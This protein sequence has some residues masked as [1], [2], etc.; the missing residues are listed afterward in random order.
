MSA[1]ISDCGKYRYLLTRPAGDAAF[2]RAARDTVVFCM[3]NPSTADA[4]IDDPTIRRC[5]GF[6]DRW[7]CAGIAVVNLYAYRATDPREL[8]KLDRITAVGPENDH[9]LRDVAAKSVGIVCAWGANAEPWRV[10]EVLRIFA[11]AGARTYCLGTTKAGHPR[12]PLYV[13]GCQPLVP[14]EQ[15]RAVG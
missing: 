15:G 11:A 12:H 3:L 5:R 10:Q 14:W 4:S 13:P 7:N 1:I 6:A 2:V 8:R 9:W